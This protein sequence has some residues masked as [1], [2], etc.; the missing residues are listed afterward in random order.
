MNFFYTTHAD[1]NNPFGRYNLEITQIS[2]SNPGCFVVFFISQKT[3]FVGCF[4]TPPNL[5]NWWGSCL[6]ALPLSLHFVRGRRNAV[7]LLMRAKPFF[8]IYSQREPVRDTLG[9]M[10]SPELLAPT[11]TWEPQASWL[12]YYYYWQL[13]WLSPFKETLSC[14][15]LRWVIIWWCPL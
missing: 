10:W 5:V 6:S 8:S 14:H 15:L 11:Q 13:P 3:A 12:C 2:E 1:W 4:K 7:P 9:D